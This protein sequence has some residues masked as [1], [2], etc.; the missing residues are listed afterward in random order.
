VFINI[1]Q[2]KQ[3]YMILSNLQLSQE[4]DKTYFS[5]F[6]TKKSS[7]QHLQPVSHIMHTLVEK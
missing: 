1:P 2:K 5:C 3:Q 4:K 7:T 6:H